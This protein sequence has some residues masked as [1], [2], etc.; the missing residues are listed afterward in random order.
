MG[1]ALSSDDLVS[2]DLVILTEEPCRRS[3]TGMTVKALRQALQERNVVTD[4]PLESMKKR[5]LVALWE[6]EEDA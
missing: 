6:G 3:A 5:Q 4:V 1:E 2:D